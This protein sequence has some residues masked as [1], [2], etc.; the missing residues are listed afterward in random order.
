MPG[1][2]KEGSVGRHIA[3]R[4]QGAGASFGSALTD[5]Q[6]AR[7]DPLKEQGQSAEIKVLR[8]AKFQD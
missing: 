7:Q 5:R 8:A 4:S 1:A 3:D 2:S 6:V